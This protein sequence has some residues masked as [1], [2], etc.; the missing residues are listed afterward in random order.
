[1]RQ[2]SQLNETLAS[3]QQLNVSRDFASYPVTTVKL[4]IGIFNSFS[5]AQA[6]QHLEVQLFQNSMQ[7]LQT[8]AEHQKTADRLKIQTSFLY[9][10]DF[11]TLTAGH[12]RT[13]HRI[14]HLIQA[15]LSKKTSDMR[16][17]MFAVNPSIF[18]LISSLQSDKLLLLF[19]HLDRST[20]LHVLHY[21][22]D[23]TGGSYAYH[24]LLSAHKLAKVMLRQVSHLGNV[25]G[26]D[27]DPEVRLADVNFV[28]R[29]L[30]L[31]K[32]HADSLRWLVN[33]D[34]V[35]VPRKLT[36]PDMM[37]PLLLV[38]TGAAAMKAVVTPVHYFQNN[39]IQ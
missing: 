9:L 27:E 7:S 28:I 13:M 8:S 6:K 4:Y 33:P 36:R 15:H 11:D 39:A 3:L 30:K 12:H 23:I 10:T 26:P 1:M 24:R 32:R 14:L 2:T 34:V 18:R 22:D 37:L 19:V 16:R 5:K 25:V 31:H 35:L 21:L 20:L 38:M 17:L 29:L